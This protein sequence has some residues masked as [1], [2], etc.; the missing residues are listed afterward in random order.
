MDAAEIGG[1]RMV[2]GAVDL[3]QPYPG[4]ENVVAYAQ[5]YIHSQAEQ[6]VT[7]RFGTDDGCKLWFG[8]SP[9]PIHVHRERS[10]SPRDEEQTVLLRPGPNRLLLKVAQAKRGWGLIVEA[11][12][13]HGW[14]ARVTWSASEN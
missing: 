4:A 3:L 11:V 10:L 9:D 8:K 14:P 6:T 13:E 5:T 2:P 1:G 7:L 12:D